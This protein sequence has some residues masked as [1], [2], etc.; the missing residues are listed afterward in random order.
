MKQ[1]VFLLEEPSMREVLGVIL[2]RILPPE[3]SFLLIAH[4]GK[5]DLERSIPRKLRAWQNPEA[6]FV[7][8][9]DQDSADCQLLKQHLHQLCEAS[10]QTKYLVRIVCRELESWFLGDLKAVS[11]AFK[12]PKLA[13]LQEKEKFRNP[14][15]LASAAIELQK[16]V[17]DYQ[18]LGGARSIAPHL[19]LAV[20]RSRSFQVFLSG[21]QRIITDM[22]SPL[23]Q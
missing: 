5:Q 7:I 2:P 22:T 20:N 10:G 8:M 23:S 1:V 4:E 18:K 6:C 21:L 15:R 14:D 11:L 16:L 3:I 17:R 19:D 9:R 13:K 12:S